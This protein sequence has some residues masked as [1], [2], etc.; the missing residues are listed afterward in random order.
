MTVDEL[1]AELRSVSDQGG[2]KAL[3]GYDDDTTGYVTLIQPGGDMNTVDKDGPT[4]VYALSQGG[5]H[6][7]EAYE[8]V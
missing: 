1:I 2:G 4:S 3:V 5:R 7:W 6:G 8:I